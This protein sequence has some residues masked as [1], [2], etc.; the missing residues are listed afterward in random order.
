M[1]KIIK[2]LLSVLVI[3]SFLFIAFGSDDDFD[4]SGSDYNSS[5]VAC[6]CLA[7]FNTMRTYTTLYQSCIDIAISAGHTSDPYGYFERKCY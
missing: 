5:D 2:H 4:S 7:E 1:K 6:E 3:G